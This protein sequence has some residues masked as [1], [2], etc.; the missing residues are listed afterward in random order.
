MLYLIVGGLSHFSFKLSE[1]VR[2][3]TDFNICSV[4]FGFVS[5]PE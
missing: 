1:V 5:D 3:I 4:L 2:K